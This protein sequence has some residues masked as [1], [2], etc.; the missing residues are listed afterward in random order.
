MPTSVLSWDSTNLIWHA[1]VG[2]SKVAPPAPVATA[3]SSTNLPWTLQTGQTLRDNI[4]AGVP[5]YNVTTYTSSKDVG[6]CLTAVDNA[7]TTPG[8][9]YFPAGTYTI[10]TLGPIGTNAWYGYANSSRRVMG[11]IGDGATQ[12]FVV[13]GAS[14]IPSAARSYILGSPDTTTSLQLYNLYFSNSSATIPLFFSGIS[15]DGRFQGPYGVPPSSGISV[16]ASTPSPLGHMGLY[17][18][19]AIS[20]SRVQFCRF[21]GFAYTYQATP[22]GELSGL[23]SNY[24]SGLVISNV[25]I[26][27]RETSSGGVSAGGYMN[28]YCSSVTVQNFWL[29]DTRRSGFAIHEHTGGDNGTYTISNAQ[30]ERIANTSDSFAGSSLGFNGINVEEVSGTMTLT[31]YRAER[32]LGYHVTFGTTAG[33]PVAKSINVTDFSSLDTAYNGCLVMRIIGT[34]NSSGTSPYESL[35][36]SSGLSALPFHVTNS[37]VTLDPVSVGSYNASIHTPDKYYLVQTS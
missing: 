26:D 35:Y 37:G 19:K 9:A 17:L 24:D 16:N 32:D 22:P 1:L 21:R 12:T 30:V 20:G 13:E 23:A 11:M 31:N 18:N 29:H 27:G 3:Y 36:T 33:G 8:Y 6:A 7:V 4:P 5:V 10:G 34:P 28:N 14:M 25:E 15:F 2:S